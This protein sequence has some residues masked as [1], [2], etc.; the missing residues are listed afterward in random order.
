MTLKIFSARVALLLA[1]SGATNQALAAPPTAPGPVVKEPGE[2]TQYRALL[3]EAVSE[4]DA[5]RY[6]E[7]R[8]LFRRAHDISPNARTMRGIGMASFELREYVEA[9][10]TLEASLADKRRPLTALQ[11]QQVEA[12]LERTRAFVGRYFVKLSPKETTLRIDGV[13]VAAESD[14]SLLLSF[15]RHLLVAEAPGAAPENREINVIGGERQEL[16]FQL[17][18]TSP[19]AP[20]ARVGG[21]GRDAGVAGGPGAATEAPSSGAGWWYAGAGAAALGAIGT[22]LW[23]NNVNKQRTRCREMPVNPAD[24]N[25]IACRNTDEEETFRTVALGTTIGLASAAA[26]LAIVGTIVWATN[27]PEPGTSLACGL[28]P[29]AVNCGLRFSF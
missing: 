26:A 6:E 14:G 25:A 7:A 16:T 21:G 20:I 24:P 17:R 8:A 10:R 2:S 11:R 13:S 4:Y 9:L 28:G 29:G 27:K 22:L 5:R 1:I 19:T 18:S 12:L 15:G 3:E 23:F